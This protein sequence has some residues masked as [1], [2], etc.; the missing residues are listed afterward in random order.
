MTTFQKFL[1]WCSDADRYPQI[2]HLSRDGQYARIYS[3][4]DTLEDLVEESLT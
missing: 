1:R 4:N 2:F 3:G